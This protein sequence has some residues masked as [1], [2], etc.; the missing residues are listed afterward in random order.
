MCSLKTNIVVPRT[1]PKP[2]IKDNTDKYI[3]LLRDG[4]IDKSDFLKLI[5]TNKT[6]TENY[7]Y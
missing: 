2:E 5:S 3:Q 4:I 7:I 1:N 6:E